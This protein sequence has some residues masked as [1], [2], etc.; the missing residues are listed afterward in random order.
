M[1]L[2][3]TGIIQLDLK[4]IEKMFHSIEVTSVDAVGSIIIT[5]SSPSFLQL[6]YYYCYFLLPETTFLAR[7][8]DYHLKYTKNKCWMILYF[9]TNFFPNEHNVGGPLEF[10]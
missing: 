5:S 8:R 4:T 7:V 9:Q 3:P 1:P 6:F 10:V 2:T